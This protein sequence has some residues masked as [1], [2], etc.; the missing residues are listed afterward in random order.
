MIFF[1]KEAL[2]A[3]EQILSKMYFLFVRVHPP[4]PPVILLFPLKDTILTSEN[5]LTMLFLVSVKKDPA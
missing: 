4:P 2:V 3:N 5:L 1:F